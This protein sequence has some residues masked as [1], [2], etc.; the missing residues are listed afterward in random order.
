[1]K[2]VV[3]GLYLALLTSQLAKADFIINE[4]DAD[5]PGTDMAEFVE[6]LGNPNE[7]LDGLTLV[8]FNGS[9]DSSYAAFDLD[10][11]SADANGFFL[12]GNSALTPDIVFSSNGLQN[13]A[14][15]VALYLDDA[16]S[17]P[18]GTS[19]TTTNLI[20]AIVYDTNDT[21]DSGL[22]SGL[23]QTVQYNE[24][25]LGSSSDNSIGRIPDGGGF[26]VLVSPSP[27]FSNVPEPSALAVLTCV[28]LGGF[29]RRRR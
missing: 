20:D 13:G 29:V 24:G 22:L 10:G 28:G 2:H 4:I 11:F 17:F 16:T 7:P 9:G 3:F 14:D 21:D 6:L 1:M 26:Q 5:T 19:P 12:I 18:N 8:F 25:G 23:G 27:G 15:A